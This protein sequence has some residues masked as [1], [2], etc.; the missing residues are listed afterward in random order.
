M[1]YSRKRGIFKPDH[2]TKK[3]DHNTIDLFYM[4]FLT[5]NINDL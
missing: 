1:A 3:P 4:S 2:N 5:L